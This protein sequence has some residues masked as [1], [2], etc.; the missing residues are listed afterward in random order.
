MISLHLERGHGDG[1]FGLFESRDDGADCCLH[2]GWVAFAPRHIR[3]APPLYRGAL[4]GHEGIVLGDQEIGRFAEAKGLT[5]QALHFCHDVVRSNMGAYAAAGGGDIKKVAIDTIAEGVVSNQLLTLDP[6]GWGSD[7]M[8][9]RNTM[10]FGAHHAVDGTEFADG[11]RGG[12]HSGAAAAGITV[13]GVGGVEL[14]GA[15]HPLHPA[16]KLDGVINRE[17]VVAGNSKGAVDAEIGEAA[18]DIFNNGKIF[19]HSRILP[20]ASE[21]GNFSFVIT[22]GRFGRGSSQD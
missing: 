19:R 4:N 18:N 8:E 6:G 16:G 20:I 22:E 9:N 2:F 14:V 5:D 15:D 13:G 10:S 1:T 17:G 21:R 7:D 3:Q 12:E 11:V